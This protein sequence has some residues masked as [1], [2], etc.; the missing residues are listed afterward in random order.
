MEKEHPMQ[1]IFTRYIS[2][3]VIVALMAIFGVNWF[4][5]EY[6]AR[7]QMTEK[8]QMKLD[9]I[10]QTLENN[11]VELEN[12]KESLDEDYLTRAYAFAY[13]IEQNPEVLNSQPELE[14][15]ATLL[16]V[17]ELHVIDEN[18][19]LFAGSIPKYF[20]MDF[21]DTDQ[22][23]E[24]LA[25]LEDPE[26]CLVQ[27]IR[28]NGYEQK[29]FQYIG[30]PR[31]DQKG[32]VQVGMAPTR[33]LEAQK[34]NQLDYILA[35]MPVEAGSTLFA[36]NTETGKVLICR[37][38]NT[39][40]RELSSFGFDIEDVKTLSGGGFMQSEGTNV[41]FVTKEYDNMVLGIGKEAGALYEDRNR[42][43]ILTTVFLVFISLVMISLINRLLK[44]QIV[45]GIHRITGDLERITEGDL[46]TVVDVD[47]NP[48]FRQLSSGINKM[49][50]GIL[51][52]TVRVSQV[53]DMVDMPIGVF[54]YGRDGREVMATGRVRQVFGWTEEEAES[55]YRE[56]ERFEKCL[57]EILGRPEEGERDIYRL[58]DAPEKWISIRMNS[59]ETG[60]FGVV[61][62]VTRDIRE[63]Q[64]ILHERDYDSL[65]GLCNIDTFKK[66]ATLVLKKGGFGIAAMVMLDLDNFKHINDSYGHDWGD[67]YLR[68]CAGIL[69][70][71]NGD[72]GIAARRSGDE[73]CLF[74][75]HFSSKAEL[76]NYME[77]FYARL[78]MTE[79]L[80]P[81]GSKGRLAISAGL[82]W[83]G[84]GLDSCGP[85]LKAADYALYDAKNS[86]KGIIKQYTLD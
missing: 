39:E 83:Y 33:M 15:I 62:D 26:S 54:E 28:P 34:R 52:A 36:V 11:E 17:D 86:G 9:Q 12:L 64:K 8:S 37:N 10:I 18:G 40:E 67:E 38:G 69:E 70:T 53:I 63:K 57:E 84:D 4:F 68:I 25:I 75:H 50:A 30:V 21:Q 47:N 1:K 81:D 55:L 78:D 23:R 27:D 19:I 20:G 77:E 45:N 43:I 79:I 76:A 66:E 61:A 65:T 80:F 2:V 49:V 58:S 74:L 82:A 42:Q 51:S 14:R 3:V 31:Q 16:N 7:K 44:A 72:R 56:K 5:Q 24:F 22:T 13:I 35:R 59:D 46:N 6:N 73:F 85:L 32:I 29:I 41:F 60:T 48:E 71:S